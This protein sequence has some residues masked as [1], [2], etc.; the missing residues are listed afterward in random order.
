MVNGQLRTGGIVD[1]ALL[2]AFLARFP[3]NVS[4]RPRLCSSPTSI[5]I[6]PR[7]ARRLA[8]CWRRGPS[9]GCCRP[10]RPNPGDRA[11]DVGGGSGYSA[12]LLDPMGAK[13]VALES[14][15][16][17]AAAAQAEL[18]DR[19]NI[20]VMVGPLDKGAAELGPFDLIV[21]EGAFQVSPDGLIALLGDPGRLVGIDASTSASQAVLYEKTGGALSRRALFETRADPL[22]DFKPGVS[23]AF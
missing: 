12:A 10:R 9:R 15:A 8:G 14:D 6:C 20:I 13:V 11:L 1:R 17:A 2:A 3:A 4:W 19:P 23:F 16:G 21:V 5:G 7:A 18:A 22:D